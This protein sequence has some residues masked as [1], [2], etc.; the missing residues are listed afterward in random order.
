MSYNVLVFTTYPQ[1]RRAA[2][3]RLG[4][5]G[6]SGWIFFHA[7]EILIPEPASNSGRTEGRMPR[8]V[9]IVLY[10]VTDFSNSLHIFY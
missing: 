9:N 5:A 2:A 10:E 4:G 7:A 8:S 6:V 1:A 3:M